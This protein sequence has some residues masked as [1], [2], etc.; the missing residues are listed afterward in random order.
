MVT[1]FVDPSKH[2]CFYFSFGVY[3]I[4][5]WIAVAHMS[6]LVLQV[7]K[8]V[9]C[10]RKRLSCCLMAPNLVTYMKC[11]LYNCV[12][13]FCPFACL[14]SMPLKLWN[15][16]R[17]HSL[18]HEP[19]GISKKGRRQIASPGSRPI[20][21]MQEQAGQVGGAHCWPFTWSEPCLTVLFLWFLLLFCGF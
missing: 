13:L 7:Y 11:V 1:P 20:C 18:C 3:G 19:S 17:N 16:H 6:V 4:F 21:E 2:V 15:N 5:L 14:E 8:A 12:C 9:N 10:L